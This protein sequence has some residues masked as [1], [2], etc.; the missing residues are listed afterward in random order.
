M[1]EAFL[2]QLTMWPLRGA[3]ID[4]AGTYLEEFERQKFEEMCVH[5]QNEINSLT[6]LVAST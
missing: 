5:W 3:G 6:R 4:L 1:N 2:F